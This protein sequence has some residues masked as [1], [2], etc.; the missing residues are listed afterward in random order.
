MATIRKRGTKWQVQVRRKGSPP[1]SRSFLHKADA[2]AWARQIELQA[3]RGDLVPKAS[4]LT[5]ST[6]GDLIRRYL[7]EVV[8]R[9]RSAKNEA[10]VLRAF[11]RHNL[12][13]VSLAKLTSAH[14][15]A[16]RDERLS[17]VKGAT[18]RREFVIL[19]HCF[20]IAKGEWSIP[21]RDNPLKSIKLPPDSKARD[22]RL[23]EDE[24]EE[25]LKA[26]TTPSAS[27]LRPLIALAIETGMRRG[28]L[29][30]IRWKDVDLSASTIRILKTKNGHPRTIPLTPKAVEILA[31]LN[32]KDERV[33]PLTPNAVR[34]AWGRLRKRAGL[35][36]LRLHDLRHEAVSRFFEYGLTVP[37]VAL[38]SGHRD[39]RM[40][41]RYTHLRPEKVAE[42]LARAVI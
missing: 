11:L 28:E 5:Q 14:F 29:L 1:L 23:Q 20:E 13:Q 39:P 6:V 12:A 27:Y 35:E 30:S 3:D 31:S 38:I 41:S 32:R 10:A 36:D 24:G 9:K 34:L 17:V 21:L 18:V 19:R 22:R 37:E 40:L 7:D 25:L 4:V 8:P 16:Y 42:K 2:Q 33:F 15:T 26:M